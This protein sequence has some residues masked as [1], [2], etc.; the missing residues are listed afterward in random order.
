MSYRWRLRQLRVRLIY[1]QRP[2]FGGV[3]GSSEVFKIKV[4]SNLSYSAKLTRDAA[5]FTIGGVTLDAYSRS[6]FRY[7]NQS[8]VVAR[9]ST[10]R[11]QFLWVI[12]SIAITTVIQAWAVKICNFK[13]YL[14]TVC[15]KRA[16]KGFEHSLYHVGDKAN[17]RSSQADLPRL[18]QRDIM[19]V[20]VSMNSSFANMVVITMRYSKLVFGRIW[21]RSLRIT[22]ANM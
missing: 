9:L 22:H 2:S 16:L 3:F 8:Q 15:S 11:T 1:Q 5:L 17:L 20:F 18:K 14:S 7:Q 10:R 19:K 4:L 12:F 21:T 6:S 13:S